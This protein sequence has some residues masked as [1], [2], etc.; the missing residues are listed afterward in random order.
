MSPLDGLLNWMPILARA[1]ASMTRIEA[2]GLSLDA[3][4]PLDA[5]AGRAESLGSFRSPLVVRG[6]TYRYPSESGGEGF[7]LGPIDLTLEP[8]E[9][10]FLVGGN[11][12]GKTTLVK[13]LTGLYPPE[14]GSIR[15]RRPR[16]ST[17]G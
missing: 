11:G 6:V 7:A 12:S 16:R 8:G 3:E 9:I 14:S 1:G 17:P 2:L 10:V 5:E 15:R 13:L 4:D